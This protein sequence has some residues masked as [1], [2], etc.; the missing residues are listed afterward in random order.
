MDSA[1]YHDFPMNSCGEYEYSSSWDRINEEKIGSLDICNH[2][3]G[4]IECKNTTQLDTIWTQIDEKDGED[5]C[6]KVVGFDL[7]PIHMN[8]VYSSIGPPGKKYSYMV[9][10]YQNC[11]DLL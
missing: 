9:F 4:S 7:G 10:F 1:E 6:P 8:N 5:Y 3:I 11:C 2:E